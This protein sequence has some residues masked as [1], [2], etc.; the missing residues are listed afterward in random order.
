MPS[1]P[2]TA[3]PSKPG[4]DPTVVTQWIAE[5]QARRVKAEADLRAATRGPT[6]CMSQDEI[7]RIVRS[8]SDLTTVVQKS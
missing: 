3:P 7:A 4:A 2:P 5:T 1:S 6:A 8:I